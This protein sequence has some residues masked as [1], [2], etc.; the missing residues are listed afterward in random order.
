VDR[1]VSSI[2]ASYSDKEFLLLQQHLLKSADKHS[3]AYPHFLCTCLD[4][5]I[6][7]FY[8]LQGENR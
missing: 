5:L 8:V 4:V 3:Y 2:N 7:H 1:G 6:G